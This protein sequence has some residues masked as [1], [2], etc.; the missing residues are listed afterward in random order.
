MHIVVYTIN[1]LIS[2]FL[3]KF[4][5]LKNCICKLPFEIG[6][7]KKLKYLFLGNNQLVSIPKQ[8]TEL[9]DLT[10]LSIANNNITELPK[11]IVKLKK[12]EKL[13]I[14]NNPCV[15]QFS[16]NNFSFDVI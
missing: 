15:S 12:L 13:Y 10:I 3:F 11:D 8:I 5:A 1:L 2:I 7:L 9:T 14:F 16:Q 4:I 6:K